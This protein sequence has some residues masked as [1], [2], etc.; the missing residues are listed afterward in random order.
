VDGSIPHR[1]KKD[2][3]AVILEFIRSRPPLRKHNSPASSP[4]YDQQPSLFCF[5]AKKHEGNNSYFQTPDGVASLPYSHPLSPMALLRSPSIPRTS[6]SAAG[7][8]KVARKT[9]EHDHKST[10]AYR[11]G[12]HFKS[13]TLSGFGR[14]EGK[15]SQEEDHRQMYEELYRDSSSV[16][17]SRFYKRCGRCGVYAPDVNASDASERKLP[18]PRHRPR[19]PREQLMDSIKQGRRL[20]PS[21]SPLKKR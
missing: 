6:S 18:P 3:H 5:H 11:P 21:F 16:A 4:R 1:V 12:I 2:A 13:R 17:Y 7:I 20:R 14:V 15:S 19:T 10:A 8:A 9:G